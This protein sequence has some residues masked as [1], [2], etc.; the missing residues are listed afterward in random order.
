MRAKV[1]TLSV[2][3]LE[4]QLIVV[5]VD[6]RK[7]YLTKEESQ[8]LIDTMI[9]TLMDLDYIN[10]KEVEDNLET[11]DYIAEIDKELGLNSI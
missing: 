2:K 7:F 8:S 5:E 6:E 4:E 3:G 10:D 1:D 9:A 11:L